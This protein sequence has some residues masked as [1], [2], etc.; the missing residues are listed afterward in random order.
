MY[1]YKYNDF[2]WI[3]PLNDSA[4][5]DLKYV[6]KVFS[7][8]ETGQS[9][10][11]LEK[12]PQPVLG[13]GSV[14]NLKSRS[15][16]FKTGG[17]S[18]MPSQVFHDTTSIQSAVSGL[19][20]RIGSAPISSF[21]CLPLSH[22]GGW[23]QV[24]RAKITKGSVIFSNYK[25]LSKLDLSSV[26]R[27]RWI[28]LVPTQL[29]FLLQS[30]LGLINLR[31]AKGVFT[32]GSKITE[33]D[34]NQIR[35]NEIPVF[36]CYGM[37]E[38]AGMIT[39]L[40]SSKFLNGINGVGECLP[41]AMIRLENNKVSIKTKS[42]CYQKNTT[43]LD[44]SHWFK[45]NDLAFYKKDIGYQIKGRTDRIINTGGKKVNPEEIESVILG[46]PDVL[47]CLVVGRADEHWV[48]KI[49]CFVVLKNARLHSIVAFTRARL[50]QYQNPKEWNVVS[51]LPV[52]EMGKIIRLD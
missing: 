51:Q 36:P 42:L 33:K 50:V 18:G 24:E 37:S 38:T 47:Q 15:R 9:V 13:S 29:H 27:N 52:S 4:N 25:E 28:S 34:L 10:E 7:I 8:L 44:S 48:E 5:T 32:G 39:L 2:S 31:Y 22:V 49:V 35:F 14:R 17:T 12:K 20:H 23:M 6:K 30:Q 45:T 43:T 41:S 3:D 16:V 11:L 1:N 26:L 46:H 19:Q 21:C 40:D